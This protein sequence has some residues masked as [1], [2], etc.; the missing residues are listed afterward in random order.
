MVCGLRLL[1]RQSSGRR[2]RDY[3]QALRLLLLIQAQGQ[4]TFT[5]ELITESIAGKKL[6]KTA[7]SWAKKF[8]KHLQICEDRMWSNT[9]EVSSAIGILNELSGEYNCSRGIDDDS[10]EPC[11]SFMTHFNIYGW[12]FLDQNSLDL[13][14]TQKQR[15]TEFV[16]E[17]EKRPPPRIS[18]RTDG[19]SSEDSAAR[20]PGAPSERAPILSIEQTPPRRTTRRTGSHGTPIEP[21]PT[22]IE[23]ALGVNSASGG[24][25]RGRRQRW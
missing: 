13:T 11:I 23:R 9:P 22:S 20:Q 14:S 10:D 25:T 21:D 17:L 24:R 15:I 18:D 3:V 4:T 2:S 7:S 1:V 6:K 8:L 5:D 12:V 16:E 19:E